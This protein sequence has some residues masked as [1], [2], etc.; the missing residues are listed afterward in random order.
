MIYNMIRVQCRF[1]LY[2]W[3]FC[4]SNCPA[5]WPGLD[6][7]HH[8]VFG[9]ESLHPLLFQCASFGAFVTSS[10]A[11][12][13][14]FPRGCACMGQSMC[15]GG[16]SE[17]AGHMLLVQFGFHQLPSVFCCLY[18]PHHSF[19]LLSLLSFFIYPLSRVP[20]LLSKIVFVQ[21]SF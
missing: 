10:S 20:L 13:A 6:N 11:L 4:L 18:S 21:T 19:F 14:L 12:V 17:P 3:L 15:E 8:V 9:K 1:S 5:P 7:Y 16:R 2:V